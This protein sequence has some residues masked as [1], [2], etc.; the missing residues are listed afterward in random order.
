MKLEKA[1]RLQNVLKTNLNEKSK[2]RNK[3]EGQ[4]MALENIKLFFEWLETAI[5]LFNGYSLD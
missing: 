5:E 2:G 4:K 3:S 1:K